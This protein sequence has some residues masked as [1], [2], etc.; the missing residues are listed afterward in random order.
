MSARF[1]HT[2]ALAA[3]LMLLAA[4]TASDA[5]GKAGSNAMGRAS[6]RD[7]TAL[8][9][10]ARQLYRYGSGTCRE[11]GKLPAPWREL[12]HQRYEKPG[13]WGRFPPGYST[14]TKY[15]SSTTEVR[16]EAEYA[17]LGVP[18]ANTLPGTIRRGGLL[19][20]VAVL[21]LGPSL[22]DSPHWIHSKIL[23]VLSGIQPGW[24]TQQAIPFK[25]SWGEELAYVPMK[26]PF[27]VS[28]GFW[29][30]AAG[31]N[32]D[33]LSPLVI[34]SPSQRAG[35]HCY[36]NYNMPNPTCMG[37]ILL[38]DDEVATIDVNYEALGMLQE[39]VASMIEAARTI[40]VD[41]PVEGPAA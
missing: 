32:E 30:Y 35:V 8:L 25:T 2:F 28:D 38:S 14:V 29:V 21:S 20:D 39:V 13:P 33:E 4:C 16:L 9:D 15:P 7:S 24:R 6:N 19:Q 27:P 17:Q 1:P 40:R 26:A 5:P 31:P 41:C 10:P 11:L 37:V 18:P 22:E 12:V 36:Q 34:I 23:E 3:S